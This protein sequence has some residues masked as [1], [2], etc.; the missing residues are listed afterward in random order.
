VLTPEQKSLVKESFALIA[1]IADTAGELFYTRL[2]ELD[3]SLG[4]LFHD[5]ISSQATKL[6]QTLTIAVHSLDN[7]DRIVPA[8][9][10]LGRR[11]VDYGVTERHFDVVGEALLWTLA[12]GLGPAFT[13]TVRDAWIDV[14]AVLTAT[15]LDGMRQSSDLEPAA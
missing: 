12:Q 9:H 2:F 1:P 8:L 6:M 11:H 5:D 3:P 4:A 13:P 10:A 14:Y 15:M 7:L